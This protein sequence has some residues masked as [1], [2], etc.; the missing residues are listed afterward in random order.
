LPISDFLNARLRVG[1]S[2]SKIANQNLRSGGFAA[3]AG[4]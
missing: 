1:C 4:L 3:D 2:K